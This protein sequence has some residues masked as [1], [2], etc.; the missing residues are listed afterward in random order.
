[1]NNQKN[2]NEIATVILQQMGG[3]RF[4][5]MTGAYRL[6]SFCD[7]INSGLSFHF[8]GSKKA[9]FCK[10]MLQEDDT[11]ILTFSKYNKRTFENVIVKEYDGVYCDMLQELFTDVTGLDCHL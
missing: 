8:K 10:I 2:H 1:M 7:G 4:I 11:Y 6:L 5:A 3:N 9:N